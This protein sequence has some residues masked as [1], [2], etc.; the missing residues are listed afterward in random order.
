[1][2]S[3]PC[4]HG[5][6]LAEAVLD[7]VSDRQGG[8]KRVP[9]GLRVLGCRQ[10]R[11]EVVARV[12]GLALRQEGVVEVEVADKRPVVEGGAV[13]SA[14]AAADQGASLC[15]A[16][17]L[18]LLAHEPD[19]PRVERSDRTSERIEDAL[20]QRFARVARDLPITG[21]DDEAG[22]LVD[23]FATAHRGSLTASCGACLETSSEGIEIPPASGP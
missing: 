19:W 14:S 18:E 13:R 22:E 21:A 6:H 7:L 20:L 15:A 17:V 3:K 4:A 10:H 23:H 16:K 1:M 8:E 11:R 12:A 5:C 2:W 9:V